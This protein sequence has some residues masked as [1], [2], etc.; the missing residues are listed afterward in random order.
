M[1]GPDD[2]YIKNGSL[3]EYCGV[4]GDVSVPYGVSIIGNDAFRWGP[5][6]RNITLPDSVLEIG[7]YAFS[8]CQEL[9]DINIPVN[10]IRIGA[11]AFAG[12][13]S[14]RRLDIPDRVIDIGE[15]AFIHCT[16][17]TIHCP[18]GSYAEWYAKEA[19]IPY[20]NV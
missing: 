7:D 9:I 10:L 3:V 19:I 16:N 4:G 20:N 8:D 18:R 13:I 14:L 15:E 5:V 11:R 2:F 6:L 1:N 17:L 12:C